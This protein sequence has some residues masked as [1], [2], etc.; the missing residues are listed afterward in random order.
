M[1][2]E[3]V[4]QWQRAAV[5]LAEVRARELASLSDTQALAAA[6]TLLAIGARAPLQVH[7]RT[8]SG[9]VEFQRLLH[10]RR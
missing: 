4:A 6:D 9:L 2:R 8:W 1:E 5:A 3:W 10:R 7:R